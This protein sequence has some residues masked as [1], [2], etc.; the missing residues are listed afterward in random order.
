MSGANARTSAAMPSTTA[1]KRRSVLPCAMST[2]GRPDDAGPGDAGSDDAGSDVKTALHLAG[3]CPATLAA[4]TWLGAGGAAD[5]AVALGQQR[6]RQ[7][8]V[9]GDVTVHVVL[10]PL[11]ERVHLDQT[12]SGV[13]LDQPDAT[14]R[15]CLSPQDAGA[16]GE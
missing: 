12:V 6:V 14:T 9:V 15:L 10:G 2:S 7:Q 16:P 5:R 4:G 8:P 3:A 11:G 1:A 13:P